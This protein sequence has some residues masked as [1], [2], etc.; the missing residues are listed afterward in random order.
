MVE[1]LIKIIRSIKEYEEKGK[2]EGNGKTAPW[3]QETG[4][5]AAG[6]DESE[7]Q[8]ATIKRKK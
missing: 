1:I 5:D 7:Y 6:L 3:C 8:Y 4:A 2:G